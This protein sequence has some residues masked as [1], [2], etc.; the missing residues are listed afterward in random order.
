MGPVEFGP[1]HAVDYMKRT[2]ARNAAQ[3][4]ETAGAG[5]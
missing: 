4:K 5:K 1:E 3:A 2:A